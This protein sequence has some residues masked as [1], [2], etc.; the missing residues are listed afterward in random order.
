[1]LK[2][3]LRLRWPKTAKKLDIDP[4]INAV[5][6]V[7]VDV[8]DQSLRPSRRR[9]RQPKLSPNRYLIQRR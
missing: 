9:K 4:R 8:V 3:L 5:K 2:R 1:L 6:A 7:D